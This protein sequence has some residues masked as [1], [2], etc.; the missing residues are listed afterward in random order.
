MDMVTLQAPIGADTRMSDKELEALYGTNW[1]DLANADIL[2]MDI[3]SAEETAA[4]GQTYISLFPDTETA[5]LVHAWAKNHGVPS[6]T[7]AVELH[8]TMLHV[9]HVSA[10]KW[11][12]GDIKPITVASDSVYVQRVKQSHRNILVLNFFS[13][14]MALRRKAMMK[15]LGFGMGDPT[16]FH[17][18]VSYNLRDWAKNLVAPNFSM[19]FVREK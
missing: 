14:E 17:M 12:C 3:P 13:P 16:L 11:K 2:M 5:N 10:E 7:P 1:I 18:T 4:E 6:P 19:T 9:N 8:V 15:R